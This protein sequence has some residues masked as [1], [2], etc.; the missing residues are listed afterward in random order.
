[1]KE[2]EDIKEVKKKRHF[3]P[4]RGAVRIV[5]LLL[6]LLMTLATCGTLVYY[7]LNM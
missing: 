4:A 5:A 2:S 7:L 6:A 3:S 1:M